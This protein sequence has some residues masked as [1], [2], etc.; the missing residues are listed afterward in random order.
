MNK[1]GGLFKHPRSNSGKGQ[2]KN[3]FS[4]SFL[5]FKTLSPAIHSIERSPLLFFSKA[6]LTQ[7]LQFFFFLNFYRFLL[8]TPGI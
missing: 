8:T 3:F 6:M 2:Q 1:F 7:T 4:S 5:K